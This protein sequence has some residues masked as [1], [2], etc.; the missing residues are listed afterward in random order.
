M[1]YGRT[2]L[3]GII[4]NNPTFVLVLGI[5]PTL[6]TTNAA[7]N[8][9]SMGLAVIA[10]LTCSNILI[11]LFK[12]LIPDQ[13]RIPAFIMIIATLVT[14]VQMIMQAY[15]PDMYKVLGIFI[16]LI[17]VNCIVLGRAESFASKH[18]V[19][20]SMF[21]GLGTGVGFTLSLTCIGIV[22]E[23]LGNGTIF[24][25]R[26]LPTSVPALL[27]ILAPGGFITLGT[28]MAILNHIKEKRAEG[29]K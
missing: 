25:F 4:K 9:L 10:V 22:R 16:P 14:V 5:C 20:A 12:K 23:L 21:D 15:T 13:V 29:V 2:F 19:I 17:V 11:S 3:D 1:N 6:A 7:I 26:L 8:G 18:G 24:N 27:F 28:L